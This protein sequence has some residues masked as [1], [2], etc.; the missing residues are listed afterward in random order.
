MKKENNRLANILHSIADTFWY[1]AIFG[2]L[3][4]FDEQFILP[5]NWSEVIVFFVMYVVFLTISKVVEYL[6]A[7]PH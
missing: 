6:N 1:F 5:T 2:T 7:Q 3:N 4:R